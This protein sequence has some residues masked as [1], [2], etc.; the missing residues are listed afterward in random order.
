[1]ITYLFY[2]IL[3]HSIQY[4]KSH[5]GYCLNSTLVLYAALYAWYSVQKILTVNFP[6]ILNYKQSVSITIIAVFTFAFERH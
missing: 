1:M 3:L 2:I 4:D 5:M 6:F